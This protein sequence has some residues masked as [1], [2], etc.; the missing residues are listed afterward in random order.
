MA[1]CFALS[2]AGALPKSLRQPRCARQRWRPRPA[3]VHA[4]AAP[5][6]LILD[7][8]GVIVE[9]EELHRVAYNETWDANN[10][11]FNWSREEYAAM[12]N[13]VG[14]GKEKLLWYLDSRNAWPDSF[15]RENGS[16][17]VEFVT[18]LHKDKTTRYVA[19]AERG[20][21]ARPGVIRL[22]DSAFER[23][24]AIAVASAASRPSVE[25]VLRG[26]LGKHRVDRL[27]CLLAGDDVA[28]KKPHPDIYLAA[29]ER[30]DVPPE[31]CVVV[32]D[33]L[34]GV[35]AAVAA[36]LRV[37][38]THTEYTADQ[39]FADAAAVFPNLGEQGDEHLVTVDSLFPHLAALAQ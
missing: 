34:V 33:S 24:V 22:V 15:D 35:R 1:T 37:I 5:A 4:S 23:G 20:V 11:G 21:P 28:R 6:A 8:D 14:G 13:S 16:A 26:A 7:C 36:R 2:P 19:R 32:E 9:S 38:V 3:R 27:A 10:L 12:Q 18:K 39:D 25:A 31:R 17:R 30:V 29:R